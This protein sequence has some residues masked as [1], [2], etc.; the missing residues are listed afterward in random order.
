M[1]TFVI[2]DTTTGRACGKS[3]YHAYKARQQAVRLNRS[4]GR[5]WRF[6]VEAKP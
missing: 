4:C 6:R 2:I 3:Y 1:T 5:L